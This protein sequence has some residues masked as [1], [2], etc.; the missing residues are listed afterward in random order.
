M[1][2]NLNAMCVGIHITY[3]QTNS[4]RSDSLN[5]GIMFM[6]SA[7]DNKSNTGAKNPSRRRHPCWRK[8]KSGQKVFCFFPRTRF[9]P[10]VHHHLLC[11]GVLPPARTAVQVPVTLPLHAFGQGERQQP[12]PPQYHSCNEEEA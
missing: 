11:C 4:H 12:R 1:R 7:H 6:Y 2:Q 9:V 5:V 3:R 10:R 8:S